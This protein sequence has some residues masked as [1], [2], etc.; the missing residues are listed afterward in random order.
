MS[1]HSTGLSKI[2]YPI[3]TKYSSTSIASAHKTIIHTLYK[4]T[5]VSVSTVLTFVSRNLLLC[6][7]ICAIRLPLGDLLNVQ[8]SEE[9]NGAE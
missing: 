8:R 3:V 9:Y 5:A 2:M 7:Q 4:S 6:K 1:I